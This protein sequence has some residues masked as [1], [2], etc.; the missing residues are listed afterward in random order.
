MH[1]GDCDEDVLVLVPLLGDSFFEKL[2]LV[3]FLGVTDDF[4][5]EGV[6]VDVMDRCLVSVHTVLEVMMV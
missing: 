1:L 2:L 5:N 4:F 3:D 6:A